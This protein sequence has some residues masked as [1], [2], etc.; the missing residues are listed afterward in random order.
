MAGVLFFLAQSHVGGGGYGV[1]ETSGKTGTVK[2][3]PL[4]GIT[5]SYLP[6]DK[7]SVGSSYVL[8]V[9]EAGGLPVILSAIDDSKLIRR[10]AAILDGL[11][12]SGGDDVPP[13]PYGENPSSRPGHS[14]PSGMSLKVGS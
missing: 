2:S 10:Y 13:E 9:K 12:L 4:I 6:G 11:V 8:V 5:C 1:A 14:R 7:L 3:P